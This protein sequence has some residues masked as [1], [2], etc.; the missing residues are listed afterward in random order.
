MFNNSSNKPPN[1]KLVAKKCG[2]IEREKIIR[3]S[4]NKKQQKPAS[5]FRHLL[6]LV[7]LAWWRN[8]I[9]NYDWT[10][11]PRRQISRLRRERFRK[12][13]LFLLYSNKRQLWKTL[14]L[15]ILSNCHSSSSS[16]HGLCYFLLL[17][18]W[19]T[20]CRPRKQA[21]LTTSN[22]FLCENKEIASEN[23]KKSIER[24]IGPF[25]KGKNLSRR[26]CQFY[27]RSVSH[28][29]H[30]KKIEE[31]KDIECF[32]TSWEENREKL[33]LNYLNVL[34]MKLNDFNNSKKS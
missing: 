27:K 31:R 4:N 22:I 23:K 34:W 2:V 20:C 26:R 24:S 13:F 6:T 30:W 21:T 10:S 11:K 32:V 9:G 18:K 28:A 25:R 5:Y 33:L 8:E 15:S 16:F 17:Q 19:K 14:K 29:V 12:V 7:C 3:L 1:N